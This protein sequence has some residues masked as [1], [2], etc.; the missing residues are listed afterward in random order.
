M[1]YGLV[2]GVVV[3]GVTAVVVVVVLLVARYMGLWA[4][5]FSWMRA[6]QEEKVQ[7]CGPERHQTGTRSYLVSLQKTR[8]LCM[9]QR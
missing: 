9:M 3:V 6:G 7:L 4:W 1:S 2:V 5:V 8:E